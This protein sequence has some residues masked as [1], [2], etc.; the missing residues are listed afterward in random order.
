[1]TPKLVELI[2]W[3]SD[4][5]EHNWTQS[6]SRRDAADSV[7][8]KMVELGLIEGRK[9]P[10][11]W[12]RDPVVFRVEGQLFGRTDGIDHSLF[13]GEIKHIPPGQTALFSEK[14]T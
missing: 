9:H 4:P 8:C 13:D 12:S 7:L 6:V 5:H 3:L 1:M 11:T 14:S 10:L 2:A